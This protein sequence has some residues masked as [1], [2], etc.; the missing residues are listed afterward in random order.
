MTCTGTDSSIFCNFLNCILSFVWHVATQAVSKRKE[1]SDNQLETFSVSSANCLHLNKTIDVKSFNKTNVTSALTPILRSP[2]FRLPIL[3]ERSRLLGTRSSDGLH[4]AFPHMGQV[5]RDRRSVRLWEQQL[6]CSWFIS[7]T[8][9][10]LL[11]FAHVS[12][13][14]LELIHFILT[15]TSLTAFTNANFIVYRI[16]R[17]HALSALHYTVETFAFNVHAHLDVCSILRLL[18]TLRC[19]R[20]CKKFRVKE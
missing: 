17:Q 16:A 15:A 14:T 11:F 19:L 10:V 9:T 7:T 3:N 5:S 13:S 2:W 4:A 6:I 1:Y 12:Q 20:S 8:I 18:V